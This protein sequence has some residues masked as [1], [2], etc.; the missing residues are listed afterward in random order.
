MTKQEKQKLEQFLEYIQDKVEDCYKKETELAIKDYPNLRVS[1][2]EFTLPK[3]SYTIDTLI[4]LNEKF[5]EHNFALIMGS[6]NLDG[7]SKWKNADILM[8]DYQLYV[9]PRPGY[10]QEENLDNVEMVEAPLMEIS[11][12]FVINCSLNLH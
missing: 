9:Y 7:I 10:S 5:P 12:T 1:N 4:H 8:R 3:P 11:S 2:I 6:D